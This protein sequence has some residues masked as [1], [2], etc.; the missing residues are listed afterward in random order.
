MGDLLKSKIEHP[1]IS[2]Q[3][4][5]LLAAVRWIAYQLLADG[6]NHEMNASSAS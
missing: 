1:V 6:I 5:N 4:D 3:L 2:I